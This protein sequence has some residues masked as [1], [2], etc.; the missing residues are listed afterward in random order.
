MTEILPTTF[1]PKH[2]TVSLK[3]TDV[4]VLNASG[5][6]DVNA[7]ITKPIQSVATIKENTEKEQIEFSIPDG[8]SVGSY[9]L[10][11]C[12]VGK[13][14][15]D[16]LCGFYQSK[17]TMGDETK[18]ICCTQF[19]PSSA[20]KAFPSFDEPSY[21]AN[22]S[23]ILEVPKSH[24]CFSNMPIENVEEKDSTKVVSFKETPKMSTYIVAFVTGEF[25][26]YTKKAKNGIEL[27][28]HF[29]KNHTNISK[30]A[31]DTMDDCLALYE[32]AYDIK[33][34]LPKCDWVAIPDFEA[35]AME[36]WGLITSRETEVLLRENASHQSMKR[37]ASVVCHELAHMWFGNLVTMKWW[38]DLW[39]NEGFASYMGDL[40]AVAT[41]FPEW[42][43]EISNVVESILPALG[44]DGCESTHPISVPV[45]KASDIEQLFDLISYDK[46]SALIAMMIGYVGFNEFMKG[47]SAYLKKYSYG[48]ATSDEMWDCIGEVCKMDLKSV[49]QEWTYSAGFPVISVSLKDNQLHFSQERCGF[50]SD[51]VWKVPMVLS[52][53]KEVTSYLLTTKTST[54]PW[55]KSCVVA[56]TNTSGFY[57]VK[58]S[59]ELLKSLQEQELCQSELM[60]ILDD[61]YALCTLGKTSSLQYLSFVSGLKPFTPETYQVARVVIMHLLEMKKVFKGTPVKDYIQKQLERLLTDAMNQLGINVTPGESS[62]ASKLRALCLTQLENEEATKMA[63][64]VVEEKQLT[65]ASAELRQPICTV[66]AKHATKTTITALEE[67]YK[68]GETPEIQR[69]ALRALGCVKGDESTQIVLD[70]SIKEVRQQDFPFVVCVLLTGESEIAKNWVENNLDYINERFGTGM[71][72]LRN[73][74]LEYLI[75]RNS[76]MEMYEYYDKFFKEHIVTGSENTVKQ[77]L[78][79]LY[80]RACWVTR[81]LNDILK[82]IN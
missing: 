29:P 21:K 47:I 8:F 25:T 4:L 58:Y 31:L 11:I 78:E 72:S 41:L 57:R 49:V 81:D 23:V 17:Y 63:I 27:G 18:I 55:T 46:G 3:K 15:D 45:K 65:E 61:L 36:N 69:M 1:V 44:S 2:Y 74:M 75:E 70:F 40:F 82:F 24:A 54:L 34:P 52:C 80:K 38:N 19:E 79:K 7:T 10:E 12:Y 66:A 32:K 39:L 26:S 64:K 51:Q 9:E 76:T 28:F 33:Y 77:S 37:S 67:L 22:F 73:W 30:F 42:K 48:N 71:S 60:S 50:E 56:N 59:D 20:R 14:R 6:T 16:D 5:L 53:G 43:M 68:N 13:L 62:D 35:G